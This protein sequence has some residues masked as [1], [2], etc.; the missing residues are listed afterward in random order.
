MDTLSSISQYI[1]RSYDRKVPEIFSITIWRSERKQFTSL[2]LCFW[3]HNSRTNKFVK[4]WLMLLFWKF[5]PTDGVGRWS[6][7]PPTKCAWSS[8]INDNCVTRSV[9][10]WRLITVYTSSAL[11]STSNTCNRQIWCHSLYVFAVYMNCTYNTRCL[12]FVG[13]WCL[14]SPFEGYNMYR[15]MCVNIAESLSR[16]SGWFTASQ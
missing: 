3:L 4:S 12:S 11:E 10:W 6:L 16:H 15:S 8:Q 7:S 5:E 13:L 2:T 9:C 14:L 1:P